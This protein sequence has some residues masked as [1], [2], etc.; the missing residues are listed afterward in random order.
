MNQHRTTEQTKISSIA[1]HL[2]EMYFNCGITTVNLEV[3]CDETT[4]AIMANGTCPH[5]IS[6]DYINELNQAFEIK[7]SI[8]SED[9]YETL[10]D[11]EYS[12]NDK[13]II[14]SM[15]DYGKAEIEDN[16]LKIIVV[17]HIQN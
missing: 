4:S 3:R 7:R 10:L 13:R 14:G 16:E 8:E 17:R 15:I 11:V 2:M 5:A 1:K 9:Y 6:M 12:D